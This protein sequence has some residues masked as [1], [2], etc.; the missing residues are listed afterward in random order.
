MRFAGLGLL[1]VSFAMSAE[2]QTI[3]LEPPGSAIYNYSSTPEHDATTEKDGKVGGRSVV[4]L[5]NVSHPTLTFYPAPAAKN[6][7]AMVLV[8]PG[9]GYNILAFDLE[10]SEICEWLN[11]LGVNAALVKYRVP[12]MGNL[13]RYRAPLMDAKQAM[14]VARKH[15]GE[16]H[17]D[18]HR[19]GV[20]GF[21][22]GGHLAALLS[23]TDTR[24]D[25]AMLIYPAYL[26]DE[27]DLSVLAPEFTVTAQTPPT[28]LVQ[29][30]DDGVHVENSL[31]Y[32]E[33]LKKNKVPAEM[34]I[35]A[36]GGHGYGL[37]PTA[38]P[39]TQWP[40]LAEAWLKARGFMASPAHAGAASH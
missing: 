40:H 27:K 13:P 21:S 3:S 30:E 10:G 34:H 35:F 4:R 15:A 31:V 29:T 8:F 26:T 37:R 17:V 12:H 39:V 22:A 20:I 23:N 14:E 38:E 9:G 25:F 16:W 6:A 32:Y 36:T 11:S 5:A 1:L 33:A 2:L 18:A 28:F 19:I 7:G 24:P